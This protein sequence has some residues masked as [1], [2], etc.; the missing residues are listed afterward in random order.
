MP[1]AG[2]RVVSIDALRGFDM[3]WLMQGEKLVLALA[4]ALHL[5]FAASLAVQLD[6]SHWLGFTCWDFI[7]PLFLFVVG[8]SMPYA[9]SKR[10]ERGE[11]RRGIY[12]HIVRRT[13]LLIALGL[14]FNGILKLDFANFR[15]AG[16]LQRIA[17]S[18][19]F[20]ALITMGARVRGQM[21]WTAGL[22]LGYWAAMAF[23]PVPGFGAGVF[24]PEG[25][26]EGYIDR[27]LLPGRFC[28]F[29]FGDNEGYLSTIPSV[30]T[31]MLGVLCGHLVRSG[32]PQ[33]K[34][35][36]VL[37]GGGVASLALGLLWSLVFPIITMLWTSSYVLFANGWAMLVFALFYWIIDVRGWRKWAFPFV[38]IGMNA[39]TIYVVQS[40]FNF[41]HVANILIRGVVRFTGEFTTLVTVAAVVAV[42]WLFLYFLY[43]RKIFLKA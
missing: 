24:T 27:L 2:D 37:V 13:L 23:I 17:L 15:Y 11:G 6:H 1:A 30:C 42:K 21:Y 35:L 41:I 12:L 33:R 22:L 5:P 34:K 38:V 43:R 32:W 18:Y 4:A 36:L 20:A 26:L 10:L 8:L 29:G 39:I 9:I 25:N 40:Q 7:A 19:F 16:V 3:F 14:V 28:C 31:V